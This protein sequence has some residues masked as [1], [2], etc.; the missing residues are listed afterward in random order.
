MLLDFC[1]RN[2]HNHF[3]DLD[4]SIFC[5]VSHKENNIAAAH[6]KIAKCKKQIRQAKRIRRNRQGKGSFCT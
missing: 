6:E 4:Y 2:R 5:V 3:M 1:L